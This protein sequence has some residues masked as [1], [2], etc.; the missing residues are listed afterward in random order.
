MSYVDGFV[1]PIPKKNVAKYKKMAA[2]GCKT[3]MKFGALDYKEC[4]IDDATPAHV[5]FTFGKMAKAKEDEVV[6]FSYIVFKNRKHRDA[7]NKKVMAFFEKKYKDDAQDMPF[8]MKRFAY[9]GFK[10]IVE[11]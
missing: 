11:A 9:A 10:A 7:V 1:I 4:M 3:W 2:E 5:A 8:E 6:F